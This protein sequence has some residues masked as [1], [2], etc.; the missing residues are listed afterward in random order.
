M[1]G[2]ALLSCEARV[3]AKVL[4]NCQ[5]CRWFGLVLEDLGGGRVSQM[6]AVGDGGQVGKCGAS[7][8]TL[9]PM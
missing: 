2:G 6:F 1:A 3:A 5:L 4:F 9:T 7:G 8:C